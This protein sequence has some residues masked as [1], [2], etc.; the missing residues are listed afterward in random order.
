M[1]V[2][3]LKGKRLQIVFKCGRHRIRHIVPIEELT[4][5]LLARQNRTLDSDLGQ[6]VGPKGAI[7]LE[8]FADQHYKDYA[9]VRQ[10]KSWRSE[11]NRVRQVTR[12]LGRLELH[13]ITSRNYDSIAQYGRD[14][15]LRPATINHLALRL[16]NMLKAGKELGFIRQ[17]ASLPSFPQLKVNNE[18]GR[19]LLDREILLLKAHAK[20]HTMRAILDFAL[21]TGMR[22]GELAKL[23]W[24]DLDLDDG[25]IQIQETKNGRSRQVPINS[26]A[27]KAL[28]ELPIPMR[29]GPV[30]GVGASW[31]SHQFKKTA[32]AAGL[33]DVCF[34][35]TRRTFFS[36][37]IRLGVPE[38]LVR[39]MVGHRTAAMVSRYAVFDADFLSDMMERIATGGKGGRQSGHI[40]RGAS[41]SRSAANRQSV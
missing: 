12:I 23:G 28:E 15:K 29:G 5:W 26:K 7:T 16:S 41:D 34:H 20:H 11:R 2:R 1:Q 25:W 8:D 27:R 39:R 19:I 14:R 6:R 31:I 13:E 21:N 24:S 17:D 33:G 40:E 22:R 18:R 32:R 35:D 9:Q 37:A 38:D 10:P 3:K 30:F 36:R 4:E